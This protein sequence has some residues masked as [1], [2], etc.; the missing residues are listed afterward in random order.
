MSGRRWMAN[1]WG[2][3][4]EGSGLQHRGTLAFILHS[5][6]LLNVPHC[7]DI[8]CDDTKAS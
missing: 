4:G 1:V 5:F 8:F 2:P 3:W 6:V 7:G